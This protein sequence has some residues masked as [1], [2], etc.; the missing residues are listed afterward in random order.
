MVFFF[1]LFVFFF[2][3][4]LLKAKIGVEYTSF[5]P[6]LRQHNGSNVY[7]YKD[8]YHVQSNHLVKPK[9]PPPSSGEYALG[10]SKSKF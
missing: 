6:I 2:E 4:F 3:P 1:Y 8:L 10:E 5:A 9:G 7:F